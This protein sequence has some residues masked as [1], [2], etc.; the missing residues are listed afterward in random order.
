MRLE[1]NDDWPIEDASIEIEREM[2]L[3]TIAT[4][5]FQHTNDW[6]TVIQNG[7]WKN[8]GIIVFVEFIFS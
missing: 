6:S 1:I 8:A 2:R 4:V 3:S 5:A 7:F